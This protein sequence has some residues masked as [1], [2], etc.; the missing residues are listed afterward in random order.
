MY[1]SKCGNE[2]SGDAKFCGACGNIVV[3]DVI[4]S[5][6]INVL[7]YTINSEPANV[8]SYTINSEPANV[9]SFTA[10][11]EPNNVSVSRMAEGT[12]AKGKKNKVIVFSILTVILISLC[13]GAFLWYKKVYIPNQYEKQIAL[14]DE[15]FEEKNYDKAIFAYHKAIDID[16]KREEAHIGLSDIYIEIGEYT[17]A[18]LALESGYED[19]KSEM[20]QHKLDELYAKIEIDDLADGVE[21]VAGQD[22]ETIK[23]VNEDENVGEVGE[24]VQESE[25]L[26]TK[27]LEQQKVDIFVRQVDNTNFP[28]VKFYASVRDMYGESVKQ[29]SKNDFVIQEI[30]SNGYLVNVEI[31]DVYQ[32]LSSDKIFVNLVLDKSG[33]ME[34]SNKM[35]QAK[36]AANSFVKRVNLANGDSVEII[37]FSDYV[38]L[39]QEFTSKESL[40]ESAINKIQASGLTALY[41]AIYTGLQ[42]TY[43]QDGSKC[44]IVF[45]DGEENASNYLWEDVVFMAKNTGIPVYII[46]IGADYDEADLISLAQQCSGKYYS[47]D[48]EDL[49]TILEDIYFSIYKETQE[50]YVFDY[51]SPNNKDTDEFRDFCIKTT[52]LSLYLGTA[53][54]EYIPEA[55]IA[56]DFSE[57]Y[58]SMDFMLKD[59]SVIEITEADLYGLSLAQLRIA[60]NEIFARHGRQFKDSA[61]NKWFYSKTWYLN[62]G[63]KYSPDF[64]DSISPSP[65]SKLE[66]KNANF[67]K[68]YEKRL[69]E[70][71]DIFPQAS[72]EILSEYDLALSKAV[73]KK[74]LEQMKSYVSTDILS[75]NMIRVQA[76]INKEEITY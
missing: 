1:C 10:G 68:D 58:M 7:S 46:G 4:P 69:M 29:L 55:D 37:S 71:R 5:E 18:V 6:P 41:D 39:E 57:S 35:N 13:V 48:T 75:E 20:I 47:A 45:T 60:R 44:V 28:H 59:S 38:Y 19:S 50:Y 22:V 51:I 76:A 27:P 73:L 63:M 32:V 52:E 42:Q 53:T 74:A 34:D 12:S 65:L 3:E 21:A 33:S 62:I 25:E 17:Q 26:I 43:Y 2:I 64:F 23:D 66:L 54:K 72:S 31:N 30:D 8:P 14:G 67:I 61:L 70:T 40:L 9:P 15:Y 24:V 49:S 56:G 11:P 16:A 36:D